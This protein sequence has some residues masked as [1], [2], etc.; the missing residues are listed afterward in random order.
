[1]DHKAQKPRPVSFRMVI[2]WGIPTS[3]FAFGAI[4]SAAWTDNVASPGVFIALL[5]VSLVFVY[6]RAQAA[7]ETSKK[8]HQALGTEIELNLR[9]IRGV[10]ANRES[11]DDDDMLPNALR[12]SGKSPKCRLL[13]PGL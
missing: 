11:Q 10:F 1:M 12:T 2:G 3:L 9:Q 7:I 13:Y 5:S 8:R 6:G 4:Y